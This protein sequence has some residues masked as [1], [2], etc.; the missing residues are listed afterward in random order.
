[1]KILE[2]TIQNTRKFMYFRHYHT[3]HRGVLKNKNPTLLRAMLCAA[4][5]ACASHHGP[6]ELE[7]NLAPSRAGAKSATALC[8]ANATA[9]TLVRATLTFQRYI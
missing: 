7:P 3:F 6:P 5:I 1:M 2:N 9:Q 4:R 8:I